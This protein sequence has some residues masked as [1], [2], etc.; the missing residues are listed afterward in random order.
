[1]IIALTGTPGTGKTTIA[2]L[3]SQQGHRVI[4]FHQFAL[5]HHCDH[6]YDDHHESVI[7]DEKEVNE[8]LKTIHESNTSI[9]IEGHLTHLLSIAQKIIILRCNPTILLKR[10]QTK[11]WSKQKIMENIEAEMLDIILCESIDLHYKKDIFEIDTSHKT[12]QYIAD[13]IQHL[14]DHQFNEN[15]SMKPGNI[16]WTS[17]LL[18]TRWKEK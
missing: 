18:D 13:R 6:G 16:D 12:P 5:D 10:L 15:E 9:I 3:L 4:D 17:Y 7:I 1:M 8:T 2:A 14:I 11:R